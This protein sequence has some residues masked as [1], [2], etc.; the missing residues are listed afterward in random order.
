MVGCVLPATHAE[1]AT[2]RAA[3]GD[4]GAQETVAWSCGRHAG[5]QRKAAGVAAVASSACIAARVRIATQRAAGTPSLA[6]RRLSPSQRRAV[7][8]SRGD[9]EAARFSGPCVM[10]DPSRLSRGRGGAIAG[11]RR[12]LA[13]RVRAVTQRA[14][15]TPRTRRLPTRVGSLGMPT[16]ATDGATSRP[17]PIR[18]AVFR[19]AVRSH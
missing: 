16:R 3:A 10:K 4:G 13:S 19:A 11:T 14:A 1:A 12:L 15:G 6:S 17:Q 9:E 2:T 8:A 18:T 7:R 5:S